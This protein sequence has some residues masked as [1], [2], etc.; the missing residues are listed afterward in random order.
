MM[1]CPGKLVRQERSDAPQAMGGLTA[2]VGPPS[3]HKMPWHVV[4]TERS[5]QLG[6]PLAAFTKM[7]VSPLWK[8]F[9]PGQN[10]S[11]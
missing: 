9:T 8:D 2:E 4:I 5:S 7:C 10:R 1:A 6:V 3:R 11:R